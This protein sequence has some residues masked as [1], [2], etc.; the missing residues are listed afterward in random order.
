MATI[1]I[2]KTNY[3]QIV[4]QNEKS[5]LLKF[6]ATWCG[7]C[8]AFTPIVEEFASEHPEI[9][10]GTVDIDQCPEIADRF[11]VASVP[12]LVVLKNGKETGR[13]VGLKSKGAI[14]HLF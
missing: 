6:F 10:V 13:S 12:T 9:I 14:A 8:K 11:N 4:N 1:A 7:P 2:N 5:V 3:D